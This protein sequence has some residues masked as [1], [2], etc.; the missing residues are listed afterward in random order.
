MFF[1]TRFVGKESWVRHRILAQAPHIDRHQ[2]TLKWK[3]QVVLGSLSDSD[4]RYP[5]HKDNMSE[6]TSLGLKRSLSPVFTK[7]SQSVRAV[8][9]SAC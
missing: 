2:R 6:L 9:M 3:A 1:A 7:K 5:I 4:V 8:R